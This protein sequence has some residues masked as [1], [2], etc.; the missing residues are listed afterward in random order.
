MTLSFINSNHN[1]GFMPPLSISLTF[2]YFGDTGSC[3][4]TCSVLNSPYVHFKFKK[5]E[6]AGMGI[7]GLNR[8]NK[9]LFLHIL[10][11]CRS[12]NL[13]LHKE[14][15]YYFVFCTRLYTKMYQRGVH[16]IRYFFK[17]NTSK[18]IISFATTPPPQFKNPKNNHESYRLPENQY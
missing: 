1:V 3:M 2:L 18:Y 5:Y 13:L 10:I 15:L 14:N 7:Y 16:L 17:F 12:T 11:L 4:K 8:N 9:N 6:I